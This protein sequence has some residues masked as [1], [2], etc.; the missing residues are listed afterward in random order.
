[1]DRDILKS[2]KNTFYEL[3]GRQ[4]CKISEF[5]LLRKVVRNLIKQISV[6]KKIKKGK[7]CASYK[8]SFTCKL[9]YFY[10]QCANLMPDNELTFL[11]S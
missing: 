9:I 11:S 10:G 5:K 6:K 4:I 2:M 3:L 7:A 1:M 8:A